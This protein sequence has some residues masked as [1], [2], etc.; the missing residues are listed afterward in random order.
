MKKIIIIALCLIVITAAV[1]TVVFYPREGEIDISGTK[2]VQYLLSGNGPVDENDLAAW[3]DIERRK[4]YNDNDDICWKYGKDIFVQDEKGN[5]ESK[6]VPLVYVFEEPVFD[7]VSCSATW[8]KNRIDRLPYSVECKISGSNL[9]I[10]IRIFSEKKNEVDLCAML[11]EMYPY[12][13]GNEEVR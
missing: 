10:H 9:Q 12:I 13:V 1:L 6:S 5:Y 11:D 3:S 2:I 8:V 4:C 7:D